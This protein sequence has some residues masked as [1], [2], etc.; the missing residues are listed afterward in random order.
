[1]HSRQSLLQRSCGNLQAG[2]CD[3]KWYKTGSEAC[4]REG[5]ALRHPPLWQEHG[6]TWIVPRFWSFGNP[7][8]LQL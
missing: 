8:L 5:F 1:M 7:L 3:L 6:E 4:S 2:I